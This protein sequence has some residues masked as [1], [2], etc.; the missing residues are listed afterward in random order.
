MRVI[1]KK[2]Q[3]RLIYSLNGIELE[4]YISLLICGLVLTPHLGGG[5]C[6]KFSL[7]FGSAQKIATNTAT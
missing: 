5:V 1:E 2:K 3:L 6:G 7:H 4:Q